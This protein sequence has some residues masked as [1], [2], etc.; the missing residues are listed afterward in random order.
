MKTPPVSFA[1]ARPLFVLSAVALCLSAARADVTQALEEARLAG[2]KLGFTTIH[3]IRGLFVGEPRKLRVDECW[4]DVTTGA[5]RKISRVATDDDPNPLASGILPENVPIQS[6]RWETDA[7]TFFIFS[8]SLDWQASFTPAKS[9]AQ[10]SGAGPGGAKTVLTDDREMVLSRLTR[11]WTQAY[12]NASLARHRGDQTAPPDYGPLPINEIEE[13]KQNAGHGIAFNE[14]V[15]LW[16]GLVRQSRRIVNGV[17]IELLDQRFEK[18]NDLA[19]TAAMQEVA[20][21]L[22]KAM[23]NAKPFDPSKPMAFPGPPRP[24][25]GFTFAPVVDRLE[26][27]LRQIFPGSPADKA[28]LRP[29]DVILAFGDQKVADFPDRKALFDFI[30]HRSPAN[31]EFTIQ[32]GDEIFKIHME[33]VDSATFAPKDE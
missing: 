25:Y 23:A 33:K 4:L 9:T 7:G 29:E 5:F 14:D 12:G 32:R 19:P 26:I 22:S 24:T 16:H 6:G 31:G 10:G 3:Q 15:T 21:R 13:E 2:E 1:F 28:G 17:T 11:N 20:Q 18:T 27:R 8:G 30:T